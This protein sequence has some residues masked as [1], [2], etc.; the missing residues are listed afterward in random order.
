MTEQQSVN[1]FDQPD[2]PLEPCAGDT[3]TDAQQRVW[4]SHVITYGV[5]GGRWAYFTDHLTP[6]VVVDSRQNLQ[7]A[8]FAGMLSIPWD[9]LS[10]LGWV[11]GKQWCQPILDKI[12]S[13]PVDS[14]RFEHLPEP[15][16]EA[17]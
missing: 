14:V 5:R 7:A 2:W 6:R 3:H 11:L 10:K 12:E 13:E 8:H 9:G 16:K 15:P 17:E 4:T 1:P